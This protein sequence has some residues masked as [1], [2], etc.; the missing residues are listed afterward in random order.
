MMLLVIYPLVEG[1]SVHKHD[2]CIHVFDVTYLSIIMALVHHLILWSI[3]FSYL[4]FRKKMPL[5]NC[6]LF[7]IQLDNCR[8]LAL[9]CVYVKSETELDRAS[10]I[11]N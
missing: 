1:L 8:E 11:G 6:E 10:M 4:S 5:W 7:S 3:S 2:L 9:V